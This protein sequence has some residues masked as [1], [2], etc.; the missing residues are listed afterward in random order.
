[1]LKQKLQ[2]DQIASLKNGDKKKLEILRYILAQIKNKEIDTQKE[3]TEDEVIGVLKKQVKELQESIES[4]EKGGRT[5]LSENSKNQLN[6]IKEYLPAE[7]SDEELKKEIQT[8]IQENKTL[9]DQDP[10]RIIGICMGKLKSK[11][12]PKRIMSILQALS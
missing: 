7:I 3:L 10:K 4:F 2:A 11:A 6:I 5:D 8:I 1:M 9:Y 12:D